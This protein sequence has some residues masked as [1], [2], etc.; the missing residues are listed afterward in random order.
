MVVEDSGLRGFMPGLLQ[1]LQTSSAYAK[2]II[3]NLPSFEGVPVLFWLS[4]SSKLT[5]QPEV[6]LAWRLDTW[7]IA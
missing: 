4:A 7:R 2:A 6:L 5:G 1:P 3:D